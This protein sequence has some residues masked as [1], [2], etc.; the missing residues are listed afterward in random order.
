MPICGHCK[1]HHPTVNDVKKCFG[2]PTKPASVGF[3]RGKK[4]APL[5]PTKRQGQRRP[6]GQS[7]ST[8]SPGLSARADAA[9]RLQNEKRLRRAERQLRLKRSQKKRIPTSGT[10]WAEPDSSSSRGSSGRIGIER[11]LGSPQANRATRN[12]KRSKGP[13]TSTNTVPFASDRGGHRPRSRPTTVTS[14]R[15]CGSCGRPEDNCQC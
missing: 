15:K 11:A 6:K 2:L 4:S 5:S 8:Q 13:T 10:N 14:N 1:K 9:S 12:P 3:E 7:R